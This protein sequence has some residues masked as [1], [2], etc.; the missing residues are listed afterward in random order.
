MAVTAISLSKPADVLDANQPRNETALQKSDAAAK[1]VLQ[2]LRQKAELECRYKLWDQNLKE[3][4]ANIDFVR[5][6]QQHDVGF[7][8]IKQHQWVVVGGGVGAIVFSS[9]AKILTCWSLL[10]FIISTVGGML[11][12]SFFN[13]IK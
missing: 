4:Q 1:L 9:V 6:A 10:G 3:T 11:A 12:G 8:L 7:K 13:K 2:Q 5:K